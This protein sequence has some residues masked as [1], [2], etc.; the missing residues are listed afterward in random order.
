MR[1]ILAPLLPAL[2]AFSLCACA[3]AGPPPIAAPAPLPETV[4]EV[5]S[6]APADSGSGDTILLRRSGCFGRCPEYSLTIAGDGGVVFDGQRYVSAPGR[7]QGRADAAKLAQ[8]RQL[9]RDPATRQLRDIY[10]PGASGCDGWATDM[11]SVTL[12]WTLGGEHRHFEH[13]LGCRNPATRLRE[14]AAAI[15]A[16]AESEQWTRRNPE[17]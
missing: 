2:L 7:H 9:L 8:L 15:D 3:E 16:A 4:L 5:P 10:H 17:R 12:D 14:I 6:P 13:Y 1:P 11:T